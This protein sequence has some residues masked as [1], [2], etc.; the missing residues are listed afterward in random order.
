[1]N[2][3]DDHMKTLQRNA[4]ELMLTAY[5]SAWRG[6]GDGEAVRELVEAAG[7]TR[8]P[9]DALNMAAQWAFKQAGEGLP[10]TD[11]ERNRARVL[12]GIPPDRDE[13]LP[14]S[15]EE[16]LERRVAEER[17]VEA[18]AQVL[19]E[20]LAVEPP[21]A[22]EDGEIVERAHAE[23]WEEEGRWHIAA[24]NLNAALRGI[25]E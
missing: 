24:M 11:A 16:Y 8:N 18:V 25:T 10:L 20:E 2:S 14:E 1:V 6:E 23:L 19:A 4:D 13:K 3:F 17:E 5:G 12:A 9:P 7:R 21:D 22:Q 15:S